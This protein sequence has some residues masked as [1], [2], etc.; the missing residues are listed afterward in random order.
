MTSTVT[1]FDDETGC[2]LES[3]VCA[4]SAIDMAAA[5]A[6]MRKLIERCILNPS[7]RSFE[8]PP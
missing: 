2:V 5:N 8:W 3:A 4:A 7:N 1:A 6:I